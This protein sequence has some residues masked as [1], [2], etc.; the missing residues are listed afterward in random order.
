MWPDVTEIQPLHF[1]KAP[2]EML[3]CVSAVLSEIRRAKTTAKRSMNAPVARVAVHGPQ[4]LIDF[5]EAARSDLCDAGGVALLELG[6]GGTELD[7][8]TIA[9]VP[10]ED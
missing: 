1:N 4:N 3:G 6:P 10:T 2:S 5:I 9:L 7:V 8:A